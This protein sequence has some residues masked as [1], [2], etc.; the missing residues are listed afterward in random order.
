LI[1]G[2]TYAKKFFII[3]VFLVATQCALN[4]EEDV[5]TVSARSA[6]NGFTTLHMSG[7][8][9]AVS[10]IKV[11]GIA[12]ES[13]IVSAVARMLVLQNGEPAENAVSISI[14]TSGAVA[15]ACRQD[16]WPALEISEFEAGIDRRNQLDLDVVT[17]TVSV[18]AMQGFVTVSSTTGDISVESAAGC[19]LEAT[20]GEISF[21][22]LKDTIPVESMAIRV[23]TGDIT[24]KVPVGFKA[25]LQCSTTTGTVTTPEGESATSLNGGG[26]ND[27]LIRCETTTGDVTVGEE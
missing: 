21:K 19:R 16:L 20:T 12:A 14:D 2:V 11:T 25:R 3:C 27:P 15:F 24:V 4:V 9:F 22:L 23:T 13:C 8:L 6:S 18:A 17:G 1:N 26:A 5:W 7:D 10:D